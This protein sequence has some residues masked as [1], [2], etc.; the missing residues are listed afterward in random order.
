MFSYSL[1]DYLE[2]KHNI[3]TKEYLPTDEESTFSEVFSLILEGKLTPSPE[4]IA[5]KQYIKLYIMNKYGKKIDSL[6]ECPIQNTFNRIGA[7]Y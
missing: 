5:K 4:N 3:L 7:D 2:I 1:R 6:E